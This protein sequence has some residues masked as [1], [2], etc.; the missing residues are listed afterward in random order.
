MSYLVSDINTRV[1]NKLDDSSFDTAILL[2]F[3][4]DTE[5]E[6]FNRYRIGTNETSNDSITTTAG[7]TALTGLPTNMGTPISLKIISPVN[8]AEE[9]PYMEYEDVDALYPQ[10]SLL[11]RGTPFGWYLF[12]GVP[13]LVN[14]ADKTYTLSLKY[15]INPTKLT[16]SSD[17]PN[18]PENFSEALV[19]GVY[20]RACEWNDEFDKGAVAR[21]QFRNLCLDYVNVNRRSAGT[22]H[23]MRRPL[24][25][26]RNASRM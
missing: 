23:I 13:T 16:S 24:N 17:T 22:P 2:E 5:R 25:M 3:I 19:M 26:R 15:I 9:I 1:Q 12:D 21:Q 6:I 10:S 18:V 7:S 14:E 11:G 8:Y 20:A 4:N